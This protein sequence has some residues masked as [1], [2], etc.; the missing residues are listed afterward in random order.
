MKI[1]SKLKKLINKLSF[2]YKRFPMSLLLAGLVTIIIMIMNHSSYHLQETYSRIA[3]TLALGIPLTLSVHVYFEGKTDTSKRHQVLYHFAVIIL[4]FVY[5]LFLLNDLNMVTSTRYTAYTISFYLL[6]SFIPYLHRKENY[7][8]YVIR[9]FSRFV[10]SYVYSVILYLGLAAIL[11]TINLLFNANIPGKLFFDMAVIVA[12]IFAPAFFL[13]DIPKWNEEIIIDS[14]PKVLGVLLQ[15]IILPLLTVYTLILYAYFGKSIITMQ[16]PQ[17]IIGNLVLWYSIISVIILFFIYP[18]KN[19]NQWVKF[20]LA[21]FPKAILPLVAM[22]FVAIATRINA[23]GITESRYFVLIVGLW[24]TGVMIYYAVKK[25]I[26]TIII[27]ISLAIIGFLA[28][29]G[30]WSAYSV[31]KLSQNH[32][33]EEILLAYGMVD[34]ESGI[35]EPEKELVEADKKEINSIIMYFNNN[36]DLHD[37]RYLPEDFQLDDMDDL[38]G[39][40]FMGGG[41]GDFRNNEYFAYYLDNRSIVI[42]IRSF[43]YFAE[44]ISY[45]QE[46]LQSMDDNYSISHNENH[47]FVIKHNE[48]VIYQKD[49]R[50]VVADLHQ[51]SPT[52]RNNLSQEEM[53]FTDENEKAQIYI[54]FRN[55]HGFKNM[56]DDTF[57]IDGMEH[58]V[59]VKIK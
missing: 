30:P 16:L 5:Y 47:E 28:V 35:Q 31:S 25:N 21:F 20:F 7:E 4:L 54:I 36:Y 2:S 19:S 29:T 53:T 48:E 59:F 52:Q 58:Y 3:M 56:A 39:F 32:R 14:Y 51:K 11:G 13:S 9:L 26:H 18:L 44:Y 24:V 45:Q 40:P 17:G 6:F 42:D 57:T 12:G 10:V 33:F 22:M 15:F 49:L 1:F 34:S 23:Y 46:N 37:I 43:D 55:I 50:T 27:T 38:F 8:L 41:R